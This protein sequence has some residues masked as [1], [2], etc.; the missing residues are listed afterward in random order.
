MQELYNYI[1]R[2]F[3]NATVHKCNGHAGDIGNELADAAATGNWK[4]YNELIEF[5]DIKVPEQNGD[6][7]FPND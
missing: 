1:T 7:W 6:N 3:F 2:P 4:K 5:W